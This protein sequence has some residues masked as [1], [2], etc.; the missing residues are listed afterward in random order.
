MPPLPP[1]IAP[2]PASHRAHRWRG[3]RPWLWSTPAMIGL[4][5]A[6]I[7]WVDRPVALA[8]AANPAIQPLL[9]V[10]RRLPNMLLVLLVLIAAVAVVLG[11]L[12][13]LRRYWA[14]PAWLLAITL[15]GAFLAKTALK[16]AFGRTWPESWGPKSWGPESWAHN[17]PSFLQNGVYGFFPFHGGA[18]W[19]AFP[20][21]HMTLTAAAALVVARL[22]PAWTPLALAACL[23]MA[24]LL[25]GLDFHFVS[26]VLAGAWLGAACAG[27]TL[28]ALDRP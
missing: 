26:D 4:V 19:S 24:L 5:L 14:R 23:G 20:S 9:A 16:Y 2:P 22:W 25:I 12:P 15:L 8:M 17:N 21:G 7:V 27:L 10:A 18:G 13:R 1:P 3:L 6:C 28:R 11:L